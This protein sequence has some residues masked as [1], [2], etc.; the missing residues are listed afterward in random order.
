MGGLKGPNPDFVLLVM[1]CLS[2]PLSHKVPD[3]MTLGKEMEP[4]A[5]RLEL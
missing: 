5:E 1:V 4:W 2:T 3:M